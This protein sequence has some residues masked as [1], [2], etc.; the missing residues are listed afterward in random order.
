MLEKYTLKAPIGRT[1]KHTMT[2][3]MIF[4]ND[5]TLSLLGALPVFRPGVI[6]R[7]N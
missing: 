3:R 7:V 6:A 4:K 5:H 1:T 2:T